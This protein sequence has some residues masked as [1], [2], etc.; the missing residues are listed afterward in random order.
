MAPRS[1]W[2]ADAGRWPAWRLYALVGAGLLVV[3]LL[4]PLGLVRDVVYLVMGLGCVTAIVVGV[5]RHRPEGRAPW[6]WF[7]A[8]QLL[9]TAGDTTF[10]WLND[11]E[12]VSPY[13]SL[14]DGFYLAAYPL[15]TVGVLLLV[16]TR[17]P[18]AALESLL[19]AAVVTVALGLLAWVLLA[20]PTARSDASL[21]ERAVGVAYPGGDIVVLAGLAW[22]VSSMR[23][24]LPSYRLL[25]A[26]IL[27][28]VVGDVAFTLESYGLFADPHKALDLTWLSAYV[29][30]GAAALHP[31]M[32]RL[33]SRS[34]AAPRGVTSRRLLVL[35]ASVL[36]APALLAVEAA[37]DGDFDIWA[38]VAS[39]TAAFVLVVLRLALAVREAARAVRVG[40]HLT[41]HLAHQ[42]SHDSL[43]GLSSRAHALELLD[44][45]LERAARAGTTVGVVFVDLDHFKRVNDTLGHSAG[46][47][48]LQV[49]AERMR[50]TVRPYDVVGRLGGDE[51]IVVVEDV[52]AL[53]VGLRTATRL[54]A[55]IGGAVPGTRHRS[56][57]RR[58]RQRGPRA[59]PPRPRDG[60]AG[61]PG[62]DVRRRPPA[63]RGRRRRVPREGVRSRRCRGL[64]RGA[65]TS[66]W[67]SVASWRPRSRGRWR[68]ASWCCTT[69]R[70]SRPRTGRSRG[71]RRSCAGSGQGTA[72]S[73]PT[74][75]SGSPSSPTSSTGS[76]PGRCGR[77]VGSSR[78]GP[79]GTRP[80]SPLRAWR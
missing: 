36:V 74:P 70:S 77:R 21:V 50:A 24:A 8:G 9:W 40:E 6:W 43:T 37:H 79:G 1:D 12:G 13:P 49:V 44:V 61:G 39:S 53:A 23:R 22:L 78:S 31:S 27:V 42:A 20:E 19:D 69:S 14:A 28:L 2:S 25:V 41:N 80:P 71:S 29:L 26:A 4:L 62:G 32:A 18:R 63:A 76:G 73:G 5:R 45:A 68:S 51:F 30:W 35:G 67:P 60:R 47:H 55:A 56:G 34:D 16:R 66:S 3:Y 46:D 33:S 72:S 38:F 17:R 54:L 11:V 15:L 7:A 75:S 59:Q 52:D 64:R 57:R 48:V 65:A 58:G 10:S